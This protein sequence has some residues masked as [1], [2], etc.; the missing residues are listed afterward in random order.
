MIVGP[1][2]IM[3]GLYVEKDHQRMIDEMGRKYEEIQLDQEKLLKWREVISKELVKYYSLG[4]IDNILRSL[5]SD[6][7]F[8]QSVISACVSVSVVGTTGLVCPSWW[9]YRVFI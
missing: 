7:W 4:A 6:R 3:Q 5:F 2:E 9:N 1:A 8:C